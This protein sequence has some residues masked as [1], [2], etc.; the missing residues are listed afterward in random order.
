[1]KQ[2]QLPHQKRFA[3]RPQTPKASHFAAYK[4]ELQFFCPEIS[5]GNILIF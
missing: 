3:G 2:L 1:L 5:K 4:K